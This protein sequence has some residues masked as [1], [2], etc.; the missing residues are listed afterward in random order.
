[1]NLAALLLSLLLLLLL[2]LLLYG[3]DVVQRLAHEIYK[4][5]VGGNDGRQGEGH[6]NEMRR[7]V[8]LV[9][10]QAA[11]NTKERFTDILSPRRSNYIH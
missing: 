5:K 11:A 2:L 1:V 6:H 9:L 7:D 3:L 8:A 10:N 4:A